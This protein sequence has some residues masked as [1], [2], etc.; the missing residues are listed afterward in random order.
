MKKQGTPITDYSSI[1]DKITQESKEIVT[2]VQI[3]H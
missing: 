2:F 1:K 3:Y